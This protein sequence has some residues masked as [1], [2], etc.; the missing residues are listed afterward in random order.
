M[1]FIYRQFIGVCIIV[2]FLDMLCL[3]PTVIQAAPEVIVDKYMPSRNATTSYADDPYL[4][5]IKVD[6]LSSLEFGLL[7]CFG[8]KILLLRRD[9]HN[10]TNFIEISLG[11]IGNNRTTIRYITL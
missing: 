7:G 1:T 11:G 8:A 9:S 10:F 6:G 3:G 4:T 2:I 5:F